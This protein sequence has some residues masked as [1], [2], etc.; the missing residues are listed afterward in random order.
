LETSFQLVRLCGLRPLLHRISKAQKYA[1]DEYFIYLFI[2]LNLETMYN[3][4]AIGTYRYHS[5]YKSDMWQHK[6]IG[7]KNTIK[8]KNS[9]N[10]SD[11]TNTNFNFKSSQTE[12]NLYA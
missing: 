8:Y 11:A 10:G 1:N 3:A 12:T 6:K 4:K 9:T 2:Y 5:T 7:E